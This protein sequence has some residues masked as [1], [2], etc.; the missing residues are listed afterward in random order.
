MESSQGS[1]PLRRRGRIPR[2]D[3]S[4]RIGKADRAVP[5]GL[6]G[7]VIA[8]Q[9]SGGL[10]PVVIVWRRRRHHHAHEYTWSRT[11][12]GAVVCAVDDDIDYTDRRINRLVASTI[13][14]LVAWK[15]FNPM[16]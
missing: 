10:D 13:D 16:E 6:H 3:M 5:F 15:W 1:H 4:N 14:T 8:E 11:D 12:I 7:G 9:L 2:P